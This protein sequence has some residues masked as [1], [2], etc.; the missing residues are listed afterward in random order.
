MSFSKIYSAQANLTRGVI[1]SIETDLSKGLHAFTIV[2]LPDKAVE[3]SKDRIS[4]AIKN[5]G[6]T[7]PKSKNQKVVISLAPADLKKEGPVFD[8]PMALGYLLAADEI[9]FDPEGR[10]FLG[11]LSLDGE[12]RSIPGV[13]PLA[14]E[15]KRAGFKELFI[16]KG[17]A[18]EAALVSGI[19]V[20]GAKS[21]KEIISHLNKRKSKEETGPTFQLTAQEQTA[22]PK[23]PET[24]D[25]DFAD[26]RGQ[27]TAKRALEIA[28]AGGHNI[29]MYGP[30]GTG[31][32]M[33]A[34]A[35]KYLLPPLLFEE[36]LE[37]TSIHSVAGILQD[38]LVIE[39]PFRA[40]HHTS[41]YISIVGGGSFPKPGE[42][43]LAHKGVL[44]MD[45][46]PEFDRRVIDSLRQPLEERVITISRS[47]GTMTFPADVILLVA[48]NPCPCGNFGSK[49]KECSCPPHIV[50]HYQRKVSGPIADRIDLWTEVSQISRR[51]LSEKNSQGETTASIRKRIFEARAIQAD[52]F[53]S[54]P[55]KITLNNSMGPRD[56][57]EYVNMTPEAKNILNESSERLGLSGRAHHRLMKIARTI[58]DLKE[59]PSVERESILEALQYR[60]KRGN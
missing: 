56:I 58:A 50:S 26:I 7:S 24:Y 9:R 35:F 32:T 28:A 40:P 30:P 8:V 33:L 23:P 31:K 16:P 29:A 11:E 14:R 36:M 41:S 27:E 34:K 37:V 47:K 15:A 57:L 10:L 45:E 44:F 12:L 43:T 51:A 38:D 42:I 53:K 60:P 5:T 6:Y 13:L 48:M 18:R 54:H 19:T 21:L 59:Q 17:N 46:F 39:P 2:G 20:Y 25:T 55:R 22:I 52:R 4:A 49:E 3:E 1:I